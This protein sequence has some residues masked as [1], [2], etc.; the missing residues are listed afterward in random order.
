MEIINKLFVS[1]KKFLN[2][3]K[4]LNE[5]ISNIFSVDEKEIYYYSCASKALEKVLNILH[6]SDIKV[7]RVYI[8]DFSC[9]EL[10]DTICVSKCELKLYDIEENL[11]PSIE[12]IKE[13]GNDKEGALILPS[14]F[15][16]N[17]YTE[18]FLVELSKL[19]IPI[20]IDEAQAFPNIAREVYEK[21]DKC[22]IIVSFGKSKPISGIGGG[23]FINKNLVKCNESKLY[24]NEEKKNYLKDIFEESRKRLNNQLKRFHVT[25][26]ENNKLFNSLEDLVFDKKTL[27]DKNEQ[28]TKLQMIIAYYR[29]IKYKKRYLDRN[30]ENKINFELYGNKDLKDYNFLPIKVNNNLR[31]KVMKLLADNGI[32]TTIYYYPLHL[33]PYYRNIY[34]LEQCEKTI[35]LS[36][37][38]IIVPFGIDYNNKKINEII[39]I[40]NKCERKIL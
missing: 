23:A 28:I 9:M 14:F 2:I 27:I 15:G 29:L 12:T 3:K 35:K 34:D 40:L 8:P 22:G 11:Q 21:L 25:R 33:I 32:Q 20:I 39:K 6:E 24:L 13:I 30:I 16:K 18:E 19:S 31:Y 37:S 10:A 4:K 1:E 36:E 5:L 7:K 38:I 17:K 26:K